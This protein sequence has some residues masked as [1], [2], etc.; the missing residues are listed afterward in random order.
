MTQVT[1]DR[2]RT[3]GLLRTGSEFCAPQGGHC[4]GAMAELGFDD[5]TEFSEAL[6]VA[7]GNKNGIVAEAAA[8]GR[9]MT[10]PAFA[11][12]VEMMDPP[13]GVDQT[14]GTAEARGSADGWHFG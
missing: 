10:D 9:A 2:L 1:M 5:L 4:S 8:A 13:L 12:A 3:I 14:K 11:S 7:V 6:V